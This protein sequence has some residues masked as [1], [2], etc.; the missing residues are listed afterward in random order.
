VEEE[1]DATL[2]EGLLPGPVVAV[3]VN[4]R[5][6]GVV[7][8]DHGHM[9]RGCKAAV[10]LVNL[11]RIKPSNS[12]AVGVVIFGEFNYKIQQLSLIAFH[13]YRCEHMHNPYPTRCH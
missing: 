13:V 12:V 7:L 4:S 6:E 8:L 11:L 10:C 9:D 2:I 1:K 3:A 5:G